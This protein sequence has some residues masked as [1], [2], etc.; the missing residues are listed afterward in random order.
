MRGITFSAPYEGQ[1][2]GRGSF[3]GRASFSSSSKS[4]LDRFELEF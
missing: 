3:A 2:S 4:T 1:E